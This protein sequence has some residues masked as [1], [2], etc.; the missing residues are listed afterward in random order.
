[1]SRRPPPYFERP[2]LFFDQTRFRQA[3]AEQPPITVFKDAIIAASA[4]FDARFREGEDIRTLIHERALFMDCLL[5]Y[6]WHQ[7]TWPEG[8]SLEAVG[9]YGRCELHP[10]SDVDL[11]LLARSDAIVQQAQDNIEQLLTLLWDIGLEVGHSVR[12]LSECVDIVRSDIT[13]ATSLMESRTLQGDNSLHSAL[14]EQTHVH[15]L[16]PA[17]EFFLAKW[18]E[19]RERHQ[20]YNDTEYNLEPNIKNAPGGDRKST[21]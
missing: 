8:I 12:T 3:L 20:K 16:W 9:G 6:A 13:V 17:E 2:L 14:L 19:Q 21:R 5:H 10:Y 1:M 4:Q 15:K 7:H 11:L 18:A